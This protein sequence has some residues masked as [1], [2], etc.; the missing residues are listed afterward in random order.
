MSFSFFR[1][2]LSVERDPLPP[3]TGSSGIRAAGKSQSARPWLGESQEPF[4]TLLFGGRLWGPLSCQCPRGGEAMRL[5]PGH[6]ALWPLMQQ[7]YN[8]FHIAHRSSFKDCNTLV[9]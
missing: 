4:S 8:I 5:H 7:S 6:L 3:S 9:V 2:L 1:F